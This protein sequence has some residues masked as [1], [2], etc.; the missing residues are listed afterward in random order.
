MSPVHRPLRSEVV[1][2]A[3]ADDFRRWMDANHDAQDELWVGYYRRG[4]P[5]T[6]ITYEESVDVALCYGWI[7]G[8]SYGVDDEVRAQRFTPRRARS[9]WSAVNIAKVDRLRQTGLMTEAGMRAFATAAASA[10]DR[11]AY[12]NRPTDLPTAMLGVLRANPEARTFWE[13]QSRGYRRQAASWVVSAKR[14]ETRARRLDQVIADSA[15][16]RRI[17]ALS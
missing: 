6:S 13:S 3:A 2:F 11:A 15:A 8:I 12:E 5:R 4:V 17:K 16:G 7:D 9:N 14:D 1:V 10:A